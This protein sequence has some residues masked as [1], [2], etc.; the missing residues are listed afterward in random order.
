MA[1]WFTYI[2][3]CRDNSYYVGITDDL[4]KRLATHNEGKGARWTMQRRPVS[5]RYAEKHPDKSSARR[6]E[7]EIKGWHRQKKVALFNSP[8]NLCFPSMPSRN[9]RPLCVRA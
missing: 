1:T 8:A 9:A 3:E 7:I 5:L 6:R 4:K 2:L